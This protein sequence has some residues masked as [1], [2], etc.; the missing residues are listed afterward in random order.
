MEIRVQK[1][2]EIEIKGHNI[3]PLNPESSCIP[4]WDWNQGTFAEIKPN[5]QDANQDTK[6][7]C[8][9]NNTQILGWK[10]GF[11]KYLD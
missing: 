11:A 10:L 6:R 2:T 3:T 1:H 7:N 9:G 4:N 5:N 8:D